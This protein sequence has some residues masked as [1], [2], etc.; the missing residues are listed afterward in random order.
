MGGDASPGSLQY[1]DEKGIVIGLR[2]GTLR[3]G[4]IRAD[5][6]KEPAQDYVRRME[7][8]IGHVFD[9]GRL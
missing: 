3:L 2:G 6:G 8:P 7:I 9:S 4:R 5:R 1:V